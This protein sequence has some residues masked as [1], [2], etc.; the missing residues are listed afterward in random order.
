MKEP[1]TERKPA[2]V[3]GKGASP[4]FPKQAGEARNVKNWVERSV[5]TERMLKRLAQSQE[6]TVWFAGQGLFSLKAA[7]AQWLQSLTGNHRLESRMREI[8]QS[9]LE[10]GVA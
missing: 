3:G 6:Q 2:A 9:G 7:Q 8:R 5:W 1:T 4:A 10:G